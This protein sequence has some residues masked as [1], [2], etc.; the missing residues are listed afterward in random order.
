MSDGE[1]AKDTTQTPRKHGFMVLAPD[2]PEPTEWIESCTEKCCSF[3][4]CTEEEW[5]FHLLNEGDRFK[6]KK[7]DLWRWVT[8]TSRPFFY[9]GWSVR[10]YEDDPDE[11]I[12]HTVWFEFD[13]VDLSSAHRHNATSP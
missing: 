13:E 1:E 12:R 6:F 10:V 4:R 9:D 3:V 8:V 11:L 7:N 5:D 2:D